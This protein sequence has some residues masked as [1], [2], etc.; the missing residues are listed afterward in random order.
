MPSHF[1]ILRLFHYLKGGIMEFRKYPRVV[2]VG[3]GFGGLNA[4]KALRKAGVDV[5][6]IDKTNH[7]LFQPMLYQVATA[8]LS[9]GDIASPIRTIFRGDH[10]VKVEMD[11]VVSVNLQENSVTL[12][13]QG[14]LQYD[15][16]ILA[17]GARHSYYG[18]SEWENFAPG[19]KNLDDALT[20]REKV[21]LSFEKAE[22]VYGTPDAQKY[23]TFIIVGGG[24][25]GVEVAGALAEIGENAMLHD[26]PV[27]KKSD[28]RIFLVDAGNRV[29]SSFPETLSE[30]ARRD[31]EKLGVSV[32]MNAMVTDMDSSSVTLQYSHGTEK[33][34]T[35]NVIWAAGNEA[36]PVLKTAQIPLGKQGRAIV[37]N[38]CSV[39]NYDNVFV[40]GDAARF[41][42]NNGNILAGICPVAVQQGRYVAS[43]IKKRIPKNQ[44]SAFSY[45]DKGTL[46]TIGR[47]KAI[48]T[49]RGKFNASGL[50]AWLMWA[51]IHVFF[52]IGFRNRIRVM[53]E[54][55][56]YYI[57]FKPGARLIVRKD[58]A[59]KMKM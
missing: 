46:A 40:I 22:H 57:T 59:R 4:A 20:I 26:F 19:L 17:P 45:L 7:H 47:A 16:L 48:M 15:Y 31:L 55:M 11:E 27:L 6:L 1:P 41:E 3:A 44:R 24:P 9:P 5:I 54:W 38:D 51:G 13:D 58:T 53:I 35:A 33:I 18:N 12:A 42:E 49:I 21:L 30:Q 34:E 37:E 36:S 50:F 25:T 28:V 56:W 52:L 8:A 39:P 23:L 10:A 2:I 14:I 29:L 32:I 43:I